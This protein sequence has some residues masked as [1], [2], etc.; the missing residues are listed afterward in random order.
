M[1]EIDSLVILKCSRMN[2]VVFRRRKHDFEILYTSKSKHI[3]ANFRKFHGIFKIFNF[4]RLY[5]PDTCQNSLD[6]ARFVRFRSRRVGLKKSRANFLSQLGDIRKLRTYFFRKIIGF[7]QQMSLIFKEGGLTSAHKVS[8]HFQEAVTFCSG[9]IF[10]WFFLQK[11]STL[12]ENH[13]SGLHHE[14]LGRKKVGID[15][16]V[17]L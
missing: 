3:L 16:K 8:E 1:I 7:G 10:R 14:Y 13:E 2:C 11:I 5:L 6:I 15:K 17:S 4:I 12:S 9:N